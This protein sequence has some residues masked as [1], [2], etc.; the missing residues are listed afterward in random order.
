MTHVLRSAVRHRTFVLETG[1]NVLAADRIEVDG[2][3]ECLFLHGAGVEGKRRW[4]RL[5]DALADLGTG[6]IAI[7]FSGHGESPGAEPRS[8]AKRYVEAKAALSLF[9]RGEPRVV[10]GISMSGEIAVRLAGDRNNGVAGLVTLVGAVYAPEAL[11]VP[12]GPEF[13]RILRQ[14]G[15]WKRSDAF[16]IIRRFHGHVTVVQAEND[17]VIPPEVGERLVRSADRA[18]SAELIQ[19]PGVDHALTAAFEVNPALVQS[20]ARLLQASI[21]RAKRLPGACAEI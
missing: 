1:P 21:D 4:S 13:T 10:V 12:F 14:P 17:R 2:R 20:V 16:S 11:P 6:S 7:D 15:S 19:L 5:R 9:R 8:L 18:E 3:A